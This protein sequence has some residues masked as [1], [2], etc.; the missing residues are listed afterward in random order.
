MGEGLLWS[1]VSPEMPHDWQ[2]FAD[3]DHLPSGPEGSC[4]EKRGSREQELKITEFTH[5]HILTNLAR[6]PKMLSCNDPI[7]KGISE[8]IGLEQTHWVHAP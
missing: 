4:Q 2:L 8:I 7:L 6:M 5:T 3:K 1:I